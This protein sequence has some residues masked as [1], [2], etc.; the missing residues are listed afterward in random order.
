[1]TDAIKFA[2]IWSIIIGTTIFLVT[3]IFAE[4]IVKIFLSN[5]PEVVDYG[6]YFIKASMFPCTILGIQFI[7]MSTFQAL[8]KGGAA[9]TVSLCRQGFAFVPAIII[10]NMFFGL[11]GVVWAQP[12]ADIFSVFVACTLYIFLSKKINLKN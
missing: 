3:F 2:M 10:G 9:L 8:G 1:M 11:N 12:F 6:S 7:L 4:P 5:P